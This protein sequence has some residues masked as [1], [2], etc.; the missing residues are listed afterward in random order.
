V[1]TSKQRNPMNIWISFTARLGHLIVPTFSFRRVCIQIAYIFTQHKA[2]KHLYSSGRV[3]D[4]VGRVFFGGQQYCLGVKRSRYTQ[5]GTTVSTSFQQ[6]DSIMI[7][8]RCMKD[9]N[10]KTRGQYQ[11]C[12]RHFSSTINHISR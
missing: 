8:D 5:W 6:W 12:P 11:Q 3:Q 1:Y 7:D 9:Q 4:V 2:P 10:R